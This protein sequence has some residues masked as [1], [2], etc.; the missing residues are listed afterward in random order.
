[1]SQVEKDVVERALAALEST[2]IPPG[3]PPEVHEQL[4]KRLT[5]SEGEGRARS[6]RRWW[7]LVAAACVVIALGLAAW[8]WARVDSG[9]VFAQVID[10][11]SAVQSVHAKR[12]Q[13]GRESEIWAA[14]PNRLRIEEGD[15]SFTVSN[16]PVLWRVDPKEKRA[17]REPSTYFRQAQRQGIDVLDLVFGLQNEDL[18]GF[19]YQGPSGTEVHDGIEYLKYEIEREGLRFEALIDPE[20]DLPRHAPG[21]VLR[22][23][24]RGTFPPNELPSR[25]RHPEGS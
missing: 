5:R 9:P 19:F 11:L 4:L 18:S 6:V 7:P 20:T 2:E 23:S 21:S 1:M 3:P 25:R 17:W 8:W 24:V 15:G 13:N 22:E 14:R 16:G 10:R 12:K